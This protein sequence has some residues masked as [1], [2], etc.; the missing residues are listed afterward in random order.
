P[1]AYSGLSTTYV[2]GS[3]SLPAGDC[4]DT[5]T[6]INPSATDPWYD[7][8]DQDCNADDDYDAD[9]DGYVPNAYSGLATAGVPTSGA[10]PAGDCDDTDVTIN[11]SAVDTWYDGVDQD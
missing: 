6:A 2:S 11:P 4:D 5:N 7:G 8:I 1:D 10:L 9:A 3:G